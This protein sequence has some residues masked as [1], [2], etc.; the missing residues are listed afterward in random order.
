MRLR[1]GGG[2]SAGSTLAN[3]GVWVS[4]GWITETA[5]PLPRSSWRNA[6]EK[7]AIACMAEE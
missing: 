1:N 5:I 7:P 3:S 6:S 4:A 2:M